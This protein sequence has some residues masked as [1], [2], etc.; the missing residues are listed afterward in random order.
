MPMLMS[1][2]EHTFLHLPPCTAQR[3]L[4]QAGCS[5]QFILP[6]WQ[7]VPACAGALAEIATLAEMA[8]N[9]VG[10]AAGAWQTSWKDWQQGKLAPM[11]IHEASH[12]QAATEGALATA[13]ALPQLF[14]RQT[15]KLDGMMRAAGSVAAIVAVATGAVVAKLATAL[16]GAA[17]RVLAIGGAGE[18]S[19]KGSKH[20]S[21]SP[22]QQGKTPGVP[23][24]CSQ[25]GL[26]KHRG[27][28]LPLGSKEMACPHWLAVTHRGRLEE[29]LATGAGAGAKAGNVAGA[30]EAGSATE[31]PNAA[32]ATGA[33]ARR[34]LR[35]F[36]STSN[37]RSELGGI[38]GGEP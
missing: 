29:A 12:A 20:V 4:S 33:P 18:G 25:M 8:G 30:K 6:I 2:A 31:A 17:A 24:I 32:V 10:K 11:A 9:I 34:P 15:G 28:L 23:R 19:R 13:I 14:T 3:F 27:R 1:M 38:T 16:M 22:G 5:A 36:S 26:H 37:T 35:P 7:G 21:C